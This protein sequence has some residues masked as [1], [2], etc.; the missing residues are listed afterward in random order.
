VA[1]LRIIFGMAPIFLFGVLCPTIGFAAAAGVGVLV[2]I[3][4][5]AATARGGI[6]ELPAA[7][8]VL[9]ALIGI[10]GIVDPRA[11]LVLVHYGPAIVSLTLG[12]FIVATARSAP[13]TAQFARATVPP[14]LWH[15]PHFLA[16]NTRMSAAW[17]IAI[18]V[19]GLSHVVAAQ[20]GVEGAALAL[21]IGLNQVVPVLALLGAAAYTKR[22]AAAARQRAVDHHMLGTADGAAHGAHEAGEVRA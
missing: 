14:E 20:V 8:G 5:V 18:F 21:K 22:A 9:L 19:A 1:A 16:I 4:V 12:V 17:G 11:D 7:Q 3:V 13:F 15:N 6:K 10:L 2:S